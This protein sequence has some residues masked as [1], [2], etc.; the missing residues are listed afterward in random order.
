MAQVLKEDIE[1]KIL[2]FAVE[3]FFEK[4]YR[5]AKM[6]TIAE[7]AG[8]PT[9]LIYS[10]FQNKEDLFEAVVKSTRDY[11]DF[12]ANDEVSPEKGHFENFFLKEA[13]HLLTMLKTN[14]KQFIILVDKSSGTKYENFKE[15]IVELTMGH[16]KS[17]LSPKLKTSGTELDDVFFHILANNFTEGLI[18]I[19]RHYR[20]DEW[21]K[22]TI[23]LLGTH[24]FYG[25]N[26]FV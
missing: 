8:I 2:K 21:A 15:N 5:T 20:D 18:E 19:A 24:Y 16:I 23:K 4:D 12:L 3:E 13:E 14:K 17:H 11:L 26:A 7:K 6:R 10:Y 1:K 25:I 22:A 9:G